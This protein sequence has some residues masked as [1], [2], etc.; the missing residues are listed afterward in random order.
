MKRIYSFFQASVLLGLVT[1]AC[2][3]ATYVPKPKGYNRIELPDH[4]YQ[5]IDDSYPY[6]FEYSKHAQVKPDTSW[7]SEPY[8]IHLVYQD[9]G[10]DVQLTYKALNRDKQK[11]RELLEDSYKL[12]SKHQIKAYAIDESILM[13]PNGHTVV[14]A[15]LSGEVPSQFQFFS[16]DSSRHFLRGALY[17][18][19]A[20]KND[21]LQP[22]IDFIKVDIIHMLNTLEWKKS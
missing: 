2:Q 20:T 10:A 5:T 18:P 12:T 17:F 1:S 22:I 7:M 15:E 9:L 19:T 14:I 13:T 16:T 11:L 4:H 8:W 6:Q 3:E 21:S